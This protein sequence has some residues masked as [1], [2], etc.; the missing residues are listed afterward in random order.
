MSFKN[1]TDNL[2]IGSAPRSSAGIYSE[3]AASLFSTPKS[4]TADLLSGAADTFEE[5]PAPTGSSYWRYIIIF[6]ILS[7]L[8][9]NL[10]L[11][12]IKPTDKDLTHLYDPVLQLLGVG[13][14]GTPAASQATPPL[15]EKAPDSK[16]AAAQAAESK[17]LADKV[18][19]LG[20]GGVEGTPSVPE[21]GP[22]GGVPSPD[23]STSSI[24]MN[25]A[26]KAGFCYIGEDRG[27]RSCINVG[28]GDVCMSGDIF[29]TEAICINPN[30]RQ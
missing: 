29:P 8:G 19:K 22:K 27:F 14:G 21:K 18:S 7:F 10:A 3:K 28:E 17:A 15:A 12:L 26:S 11:F 6:L 20:S 25:S 1:L 30:L 4:V 16:A 5:T 23:D 2:S 9:L 24:Q 13:A